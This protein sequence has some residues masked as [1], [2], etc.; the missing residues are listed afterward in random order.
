MSPQCGG[1]GEGPPIL[2][3]CHQSPDKACCIAQPSWSSWATSEPLSRHLLCS[4]LLYPA[5]MDE[6]RR[7]PVCLL[8]QV[9]IWSLS[10]CRWSLWFPEKL[11]GVYPDRNKCRCSQRVSRKHKTKVSWSFYFPGQFEKCS[12]H[13][14]EELIAPVRVWHRKS[15]LRETV[16]ACCSIPSPKSRYSRSRLP[17][18]PCLASATT[19]HV[20]PPALVFPHYVGVLL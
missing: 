1:T 18:Q 16:P 12:T 2:A 19:K 7:V 6:K 20:D 4:N 5:T 10:Y 3:G 17:A 11:N 13:R 14:N 15:F 8:H 9:G